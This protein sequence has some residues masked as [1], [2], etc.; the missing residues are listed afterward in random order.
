MKQKEK[1]IFNTFAVL[2]K[3]KSMS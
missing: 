2:Q 1:F 3:K